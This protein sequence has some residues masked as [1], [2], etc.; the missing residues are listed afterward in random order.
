MLLLQF[1]RLG[2]A[3]ADEAGGQGAGVECAQSGASEGLHPPG[4]H[5]FAEKVVDEVRV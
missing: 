4:M 2:H 5:I 3:L 1:V